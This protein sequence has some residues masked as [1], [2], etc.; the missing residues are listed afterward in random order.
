MALKKKKIEQEV[1][2]QEEEVLTPDEV[3]AIQEDEKRRIEASANM[4]R[5]QLATRIVSETFHLGDDYSVVSFNDKGKVVAVSL[6]NS[7][8]NIAVTIKNSEA[9]GMFMPD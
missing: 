2:N 9:H 3:E 5:L 6:A 8:F 1:D 7:D 4:E